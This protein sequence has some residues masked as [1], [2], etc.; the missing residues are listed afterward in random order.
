MK[1]VVPPWKQRPKELNICFQ[2]R[3]YLQKFPLLPN[4]FPFSSPACHT[5]W[6]YGV[7][8][9]PYI[10]NNNVTLTRCSSVRDSDD[11]SNA[12]DDGSSVPDVTDDD[13]GAVDDD[14]V[15]DDGKTNNSSSWLACTTLP[16]G[17]QTP[18]LKC[19]LNIMVPPVVPRLCI[20]ISFFHTH[21]R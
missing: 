2:A 12:T 11:G 17:K 14:T 7:G 18:P 5:V 13:S 1:R 16:R 19:F 15:N 6:R 8:G 4:G 21:T 3:I 10:A 9:L 20:R